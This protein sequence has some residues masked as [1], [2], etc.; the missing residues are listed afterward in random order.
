[1]I[2]RF[3]HYSE[4]LVQISEE[5]MYG[6]SII[7]GSTAHACN[8]LRDCKYTRKTSRTCLTSSHSSNCM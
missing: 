6:V 2:V 5:E 3:V 7:R 1:M 8:V 4:A